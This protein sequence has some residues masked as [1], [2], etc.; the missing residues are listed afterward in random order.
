MFLYVRASE[1]HLI[2][3]QTIGPNRLEEKSMD[4]IQKF[5][6]GAMAIVTLSIPLQFLLFW[7]YNHYGHPWKR[8]LAIDAPVDR[9]NHLDLGLSAIPQNEE[10][11]CLATDSI[12][13]HVNSDN[14]MED[15]KT[16]VEENIINSDVQMLPGES[17][18]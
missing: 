5:V 16:L 9:K 13:S 14:E 12:L 15:D 3:E 7:I 17:A 10:N 2:L 4:L 6:I 11:S 8:F 1:R 18:V